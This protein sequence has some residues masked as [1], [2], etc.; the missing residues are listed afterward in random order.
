MLKGR[1]IRP[2]SGRA[3]QAIFSMLGRDVVDAA[4]L[5]LFAGSGA[6]GIESLSRGAGAAVFVDKNPRAVEIIRA[7]LKRTK[8]EDH[9]EVMS[10]DFRLALAR[11]RQQGL[12][13]NLVFLDP[14]Y[15][16]EFLGLALNNLVEQGLLAENARV[17]AE[18]PA[19]SPLSRTEGLPLFQVRRYGSIGITVL[20]GMEPGSG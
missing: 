15:R 10:C 1:D 12:M 18:H 8:L 14:P 4:V 7:N 2:T 9:A 3:R 20:G 16:T 17:I 5:D 19:E 13:F 11:F 6:L